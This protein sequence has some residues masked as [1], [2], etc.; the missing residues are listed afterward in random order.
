MCVYSRANH[1]VLAALD[2][3]GEATGA[4]IGMVQ[5]GDVGRYNR[6]NRSLS[7]FTESAPVSP[8]AIHTQPLLID[9][10]NLSHLR[11]LWL[12]SKSIRA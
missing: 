5:G 9:P 8:R 11:C 6:A 12:N 1:H 7:H 10:G 3:K 4:A 2:E